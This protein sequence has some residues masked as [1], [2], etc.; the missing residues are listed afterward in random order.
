MGGSF[1]LALGSIGRLR[2][3][4]QGRLAELECRFKKRP[5][6]IRKIWLCSTAPFISLSLRSASGG[7]TMPLM[8]A[9]HRRRRSAA[10]IGRLVIG[11]GELELLLVEC[12]GNGLASQS[13]I[14]PKDPCRPTKAEHRQIH[15]ED[16]TK[17]IFRKRGEKR[18][19]IAKSLVRDAYVSAKLGKGFDETIAAMDRCRLVRNNFAHCQ[20]GQSRKRGLFFTDLEDA[21]ETSPISLRFHYASQDVLDRLEDYFWITFQWL[22]YLS[23]EF[24]VRKKL[25]LFDSPAIPGR[26]PVLPFDTLLFPYK[27]P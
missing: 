22:D 26:I 14:D 8:P 2:L 1:R 9:F 23:K 24:A 12:V 13:P 10:V 6:Q 25:T 17:R 11:Y 15:W 3:A 27:D 4:A 5:R 20:F 19:N 7:F 16:A 18:I 21:I